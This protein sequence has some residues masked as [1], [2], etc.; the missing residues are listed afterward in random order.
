MTSQPCRLKE[1]FTDVKEE[2]WKEFTELLNTNVSDEGENISMAVCPL[3][4]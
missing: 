1:N 4:F 3:I 2:L